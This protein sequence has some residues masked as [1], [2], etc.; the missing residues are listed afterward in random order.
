MP[1]TFSVQ[2]NMD[3]ALKGGGG[4]GGGGGLNNPSE[5]MRFTQ[6]RS[7]INVDTCAGWFESSLG[8]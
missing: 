7:R 5:H 1:I 6:R 2:G 4:W 3:P 8:T